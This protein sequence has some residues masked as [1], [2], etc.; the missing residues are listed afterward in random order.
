MTQEPVEHP[1]ALLALC[2]DE[3]RLQRLEQAL[4][5]SGVACRLATEGDLSA[6]VASLASNHHD[7]CLLDGQLDPGACLLALQQARAQGWRMPLVLLAP[8]SAPGIQDRARALGAAATLDPWDL[9]PAALGAC[10][11]LARPL[12][13]QIRRMEGKR[14]A[15]A[16]ANAELLRLKATLDAHAIVSVTDAAGTIL[17]VNPQFCQVSGYRPEEILGRNHRI[18]KSGEHPDGLYQNLWAV[19]SRGDT[20]HGEICNRRK[21]GSLYWVR[22]TIVPF[23]DGDGLPYRYISIRT[24]VTAIKASEARIRLL[25]QALEASGDGIIIADTLQ[26][27]TPLAYVNSAFERMSSYPRE[28]LLGRNG[29]MLL[30][31][32]TQ[33]PAIAE[34]S[35]AL[36]QCRPIRTLLRLRRK[37]GSPIWTD[38]SFAPVRDDSGRLTHY[39]GSAQDQTD[40]I[41]MEERLRQSEERLRRSQTYAEIGTWDWNIA[42]GELYWSESIAPLFGYGP[43]VETTYGN[44]LAAIH[45]E[46]R[47]LVEEAI[48]TCLE[49][50]KKYDIEHR[51]VWP[52]GTVRWLLERGDVS[53]DAQ[54]KPLHMLGLVQDITERKRTQEKLAASQTTLTHAQRIAHLGSWTL[55]LATGELAWTEEVFRI[56][57]RDRKTFIPTAHSFLQTVHPEDQAKVKALTTQAP[58]SGLAPLV[59]RIRRP[60]GGLRYVQTMAELTLNPRGTPTTLTGTVQDITELK[61]AEAFARKVS[62]RFRD[63]VETS[64]D[65]I[66]ETDALGY[67]TYASPRIMDLLGYPQEEVIGRSPVSLLMAGEAERLDAYRRHVM[68][69]RIPFI[70]NIRRCRHRDGRIV[71]IESSGVPAFNAQGEFIG[72]RGVDRDVTKR[73][74]REQEL[75]AAK[76]EAERANQAKSAFLSGMSHELR[77]PLNA[78][79][80]FAQLMGLNRELP[81]D[82]RGNLEEILKAGRHLLDLVNEVLDLAKVE[83][84][85][86]ELSLEPVSFDELAQS[87]INL[88]RPLASQRDVSLR[89][90][91]PGDDPVWFRAD[92]LRTKQV[93]VNLLSNA[94]KYNHPGGSA[95]LRLAQID[96]GP[97]RIEVADTGPGLSPEA[98]QAL[99]QPFQRL[100]GTQDIEGT[101][102]GLVISKR[103]VEAMGGQIG[104]DSQPG[105]GSTFWLELPVIDPPLAAAPALAPPAEIPPP[106]P[107]AGALLYIEDN[108]ANLR[109]MEQIVAGQPGLA[110]TS[111]QTPRGGLDLARQL[112]PDVILLDIN[113]PGM[114][115]YRIRERLLAHPSTAGIPVIAIS[116]SAMHEDLRRARQARFQAF[117]SKPIHIPQFLST[118]E[119]ILQGRDPLAER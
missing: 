41:E 23:T 119:A 36:D 33:Q 66:W 62:E 77:T 11:S 39:V 90:E 49:G 99:F 55:D 63:L 108:P 87:T 52:D 75:E 58:R 67:Y 10:L 80:G 53:R 47:P 19:I 18:L 88:L 5:R 73:M 1:L 109:L 83:S 42:T 26:P 81:P 37:D 112:R 44:F 103:L 95:T 50:G 76:A 43:M 9:P 27:D 85:K 60:D 97:L 12:G 38:F 45:P 71:I 91:P 6:A 111:A 65:W 7:L 114:D 32:E 118:L 64:A 34:L 14:A 72:Y 115:G 16:R 92:R 20:W 40:R 4:K 59:A 79:L 105:A 25:A 13:H 96:G 102:I 17:E 70:N 117:L 84:G 61:E 74:E 3:P 8:A 22:S 48:R 46:D 51:V 28:A 68:T 35:R 98:Q 54:G 82:Q 21:D 101:G 2:T 24:D 110:L 94:I 78:I 89:L 69:E 56:F 93:I 15:L 100:D 86:V 57:G 31:T 104:V 116:A 30:D 29:K 113:L 106:G 107:L